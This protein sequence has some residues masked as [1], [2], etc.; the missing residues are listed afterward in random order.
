M[1]RSTLAKY[2]ENKLIQ[3]K[4]RKHKTAPFQDTAPPYRRALLLPGVRMSQVNM[5][6][7]VFISVRVPVCFLVGEKDPCRE[8]Y[9]V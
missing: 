5:R 8:S 2:L 6:C 4:K 9:I 1:L 3:K 7:A